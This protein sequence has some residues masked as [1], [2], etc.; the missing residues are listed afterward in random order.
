M[1]ER[2]HSGEG[3]PNGAHEVVLGEV[4]DDEVAS[5]R[6]NDGG[7]GGVDEVGGEVEGGQGGD[8]AEDGG[9]GAGERKVGEAHG[10]DGAGEGVAGDAAPPAWGGGG[11]VPGG[12]GIF[13]VGKVP[14]CFE[15]KETVLG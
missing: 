9:E 8:S 14:S 4:E 1:L 11:R 2:D 5:R 3:V 15:E 12:E 7:E 10:G 6:S 13:R